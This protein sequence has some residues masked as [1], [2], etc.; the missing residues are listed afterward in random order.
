[1]EKR[2]LAIMDQFFII[3]L[4]LSGEENQDEV[5]IGHIL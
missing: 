4:F 1:M 5:P 3:L 2:F